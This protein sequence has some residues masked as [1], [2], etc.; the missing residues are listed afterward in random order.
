MRHEVFAQPQG[1]R[2]GDGIV[3][4]VYGP[5]YQNWD[6]SLAKIFSITERQKLEFRTEFFNVWNHPNFNNPTFV[7][8]SGPNFG[9]ITTTVGSPRIIQFGFRYSF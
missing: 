5:R 7:D 9:A 3:G 2:F 6:F 4:D 8:I 1:F